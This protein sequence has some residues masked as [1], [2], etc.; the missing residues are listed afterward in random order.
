MSRYKISRLLGIVLALLFLPSVSTTQA[1][2][3]RLGVVIQNLAHGETIYVSPSA[4]LYSIYINGWVVTSNPEPTLIKLQLELLREN[5]VTARLAARANADGSFSFSVTANPNA[6]DFP[7]PHTG[8]IECHFAS[9]IAFPPGKV[10]VRIIATDPAG[11][12]AIAERTVIVDYAGTALIPIQVVDA[13]RPTQPLAQIPVLGSARIYLWRGRT[14]AATTDRNGQA[15]V[16]VEALAQTSTRYIF[17][18]PPVVVNGVLYESVESKSVTLRPGQAQSEM[19]TLSVRAR[20][21][22]ITG[23]IRG[24]A[25]DVALTLRAIDANTGASFV[26]TSRANAFAFTDLPVAAYFIVLDPNELASRSFVASPIQ[27]DLTTAPLAQAMLALNT[28]SA[29]PRTVRGAIRTATGEPVAFAWVV[30]EAN[31]ARTNPATGEFILFDVPADAQTIRV[32]APGFWSQSVAIKNDVPISIMLAPRNDLRSIA[33]GS[34]ALMIPPATLVESVG[35]HLILTHGWMWGK[36]TGTFLLETAGA[37]ITLDHARIAI[38]R[39]PERAWLYVLEGKANVAFDAS[40]QT[41]VNAGQM[42]AIDSHAK[43]LLA[44]TMDAIVI[45]TLTATIN[46]PSD[47][48]IEP[49]LDVQASNLLA[50]FGISLA[51]LVTFA[52]Y[53]VITFALVSTPFVIGLVWR[54]LMRQNHPTG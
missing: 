10:L 12:Q 38:E 32:I 7:D 51:Q 22:Q 48:V 41:T 3:V 43:N 47:F 24:A 33:W 20:H 40:H 52:T 36:G 31:I 34:G 23:T 42:L 44:V 53:L 1:Q 26:T 54:R 6:T 19:V 30:N 14:G 45:R 16:E 27:V 15:R 13:E 50:Q 8:C 2:P 39:Q 11:N 18:V 37:T 46:P 49:T 17:N 9:S 28:T 5:Q 29:E 21:G 4:Y 25:G 35:N